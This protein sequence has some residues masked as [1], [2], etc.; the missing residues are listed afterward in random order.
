MEIEKKRK[1]TI[2]LN[3]IKY[4]GINLVYHLNGLYQEN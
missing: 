1:F 3:E 2:F 4:L